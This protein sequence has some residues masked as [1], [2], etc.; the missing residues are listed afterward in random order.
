MCRC[1][2]VRN[3]LTGGVLLAYE[4]YRVVEDDTYTTTS[5]SSQELEPITLIK[6]CSAPVR[7]ATYLLNTPASGREYG[8]VQRL[9]STA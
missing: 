2:Y 7:S 4:A 6:E 5:G 3:S 8:I 9:Q 1:R